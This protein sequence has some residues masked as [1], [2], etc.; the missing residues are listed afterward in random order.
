MNSEESGNTGTVCLP[1]FVSHFVQK[2][3]LMTLFDVASK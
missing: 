3:A 1:N 2:V